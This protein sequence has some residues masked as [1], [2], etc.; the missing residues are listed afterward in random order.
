[1]FHSF[2]D[3]LGFKEFINNYELK[4][5]KRLFLHL[6]RAESIYYVGWLIGS[7]AIKGRR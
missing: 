2:F 5:A 6:L 3:V 4:E 1:M 7:K